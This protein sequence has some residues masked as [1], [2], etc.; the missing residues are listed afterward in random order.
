MD[1]FPKDVDIRESSSL[2]V[3]DRPIAAE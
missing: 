1:G 2:S 3:G